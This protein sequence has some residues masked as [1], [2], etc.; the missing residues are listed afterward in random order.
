M[1][2]QL[3]L[4]MKIIIGLHDAYCKVKVAQYFYTW[5]NLYKIR[6]IFGL[7]SDM[8]NNLTHSY[9]NDVLGSLFA[10]L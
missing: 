5:I 6:V 8:H 7:F 2:L 10:F 9:V 3:C 1:I 4:L